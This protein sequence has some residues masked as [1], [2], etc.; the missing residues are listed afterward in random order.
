MIITRA[1]ARSASAEPVRRVRGTR[2]WMASGLALRVEASGVRAPARRCACAGTAWG[3]SVT[4]AV[5]DVNAVFVNVAVAPLHIKTA[6]P[7][8]AEMSIRGVR[9]QR[10]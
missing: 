4:V 7:C 10:E 1:C 9:A 5:L 2:W 8:G 6:P 3:A